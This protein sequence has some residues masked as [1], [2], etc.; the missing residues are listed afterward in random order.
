MEKFKKPTKK[1]IN[2]VFEIG[3][4]LQGKID[5]ITPIIIADVC[6]A[7]ENNQTQITKT[8]DK[9][10][11]SDD[12]EMKTDVKRFV[13]KSLQTLIKEKPT[14]EQLLGDDASC[15][16]MSVKKVN[17]SMVDNKD[18]IYIHNY[19]ESDLG[20]YRVVLM[21]KKEKKDLSLAQELA[22]W[23]R[24]QK[25]NELFFGTKADAK[26]LTCYNLDLL[27]ATIDNLE[28]GIEEI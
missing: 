16:L 4:S 1:Q 2:E 25:K 8:I 13:G 5:Q 15:L 21:E 9:I 26:D 22:K 20:S 17:K 28:R 27:K 23:M 18:G 12:E 10:L 24:S 3:C 6:N 7:D 11:A 14:Q 19:N